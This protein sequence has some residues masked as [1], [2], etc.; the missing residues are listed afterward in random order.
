MCMMT[1]HFYLITYKAV[2]SPVHFFKEK[3]IVAKSLDDF[4][5]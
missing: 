4:C 5:T 3:E 1:F 2:L